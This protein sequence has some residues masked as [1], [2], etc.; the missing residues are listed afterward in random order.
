M[1]YSRCGQLGNV[2]EIFAVIQNLRH[3]VRRKTGRKPDGLDFSLDAQTKIQILNG[4]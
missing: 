2:A 1:S 3:M 4:L